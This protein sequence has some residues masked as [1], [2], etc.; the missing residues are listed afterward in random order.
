MVRRILC[1]MLSAMLL[2]SVSPAVLADESRAE[3]I[4]QKYELLLKLNIMEPSGK[5]TYDVFDEVSK[6]SFIN[7]VCNIIGDFGYGEKHNAEAIAFAE[8]LGFIDA[9]QDDLYKEVPYREAVTII[10][11]LLGCEE[12]AQAKGGFPY[13]YMQIANQLGILDGVE[14]G[15]EAPLNRGNV[16]HLLYNSLY[17]ETEYESSVLYDYKRIY[18]VEGVVRGTESASLGRDG[19][20]L[21]GKIDIGGMVFNTDKDFSDLLG[22]RVE[23][24]VRD[25]K[26]DDD[27]LIHIYEYGNDVIT[28]EGENITEVSEE[29]DEIRYYE[30]EKEKKVSVSSVADI[31]YNG[32]PL[33]EYSN[34]SFEIS[35]GNIRL[36]DNDKNP[37]YDTVFIM[38]YKTVIAE[39]IQKRDMVVKNKL[40]YDDKNLSVS[41]KE[42][43]EDIVKIVKNGRE[44][45]FADIQLGDV[46]RVS[47]SVAN[48]K[49]V[50]SAE[51]SSEVIEGTATKRTAKD[52]YT[53]LTVDGAEYILSDSLEKALEAGDAYGKNPQTG[54]AYVFRLD[55]RGRIAFVEEVTDG[56]RYAIAFAVAGDGVFGV[57]YKIKLFTDKG[58]W[59]EYPIAEKIVYDGEKGKYTD[60]VIGG[61]PTGINGEVSVIAYKLSKD[62]EIT[63]IDVPDLYDGDGNGGKFNVTPASSLHYFTSQTTFESAYY[64]G[65]APQIWFISGSDSVNDEEAYSLGQKS[66][67]FGDSKYNVRAYNVDAFGFSDLF[68]IVKDADALYRQRKEADFILVD[69]IGQTVNSEG[70]AEDVVIGMSGIYESVTYPVKDTTYVGNLK[71]GNIIQV[72][73]DASGKISEMPVVTHSADSERAFNLPT[74]TVL[75]SYDAIVKGTV[76]K[77]DCTDYKIKFSCGNLGSVSFRSSANTVVFEYDTARNQARRISIG[78]IEIGS[79]AVVKVMGS[80]IKTIVIYK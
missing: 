66:D 40:T 5:E 27:M 76:E 80:G 8:G 75:H 26:N 53:V 24:F 48:G 34:E 62:N 19:G 73:T 13:G 25:N 60:D 61:L 44:I 11:R 38:E 52:G 29:C 58:E 50:V 45:T 36:I 20:S 78:D 74:G 67:L 33:K 56:Y 17:A 18:R 39:Y 2:L 9:G 42:E 30:G 69:S 72:I 46:L 65:A 22:M 28:I 31:L 4:E 7:Y 15:A 12:A 41:F 1:L 32:Q 23:A 68:L 35:D 16:I 70:E 21:K 64:L 51:V 49:R 71:K 63:E 47:E 37:G 59:K 14:S 55:S 57:D 10:V 79:Y 54:M 3:T 6:S 43:N 77:N